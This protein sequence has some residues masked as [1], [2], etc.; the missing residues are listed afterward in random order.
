MKNPQEHTEDKRLTHAPYTMKGDETCPKC[1]HTH[2]VLYLEGEEL[3]DEFDCAVCG[4]SMH[5]S[6]YYEGEVPEEVKD[7]AIAGLE[8][9]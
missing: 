3:P 5:C 1:G 2:E 4:F 7:R 6:H 9:A 8:E